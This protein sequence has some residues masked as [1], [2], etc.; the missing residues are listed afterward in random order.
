MPDFGIPHPNYF[1]C[2]APPCFH[3][4]ISDFWLPAACGGAALGANITL[5]LLLLLMLLTKACQF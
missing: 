4:E 2:V 3:S 5:L 1:G